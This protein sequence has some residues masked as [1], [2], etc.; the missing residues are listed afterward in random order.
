MPTTVVT[1][2]AGFIGSHVCDALLADGHRVIVVDNFCTGRP[3]NLAHLGHEPRLEL[4]ERDACD[5]LELP[6]RVDYVLHLASPASPSPVSPV[7]Y[8]QLPIETLRAGSVATLAT[9]ELARQHGA[10]Y[11]LASTSE[12]YGDPQVNPQPEDYPG[13]VSPVAL[14]SCYDEAKRFA[15]AA[16]M[17]YHRKYGLRTRIARIFNTYGPRMRV[18]DGRV[19]PN[20]ICQALTEQPLT[21]YG[22][23][24]QTRSFC[25][26]EDLVRGLIR[27]LFSDVIQP[28]NLG[29]PEAIT[30][31]QLAR[32]VL[33]VTGST[34]GILYQPAPE[35]D[36]QLRQP[37]IRRA[38]TLLGW[39][40]RV[41]RR[42]GLQATIDYFR[43]ELKRLGKLPSSA[44]R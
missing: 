30:I 18:D 6:G 25:Y 40:P 15:E 34:V 43:H 27:L 16:T 44:A 31:E 5:P 13:N 26:I 42:F 23:G 32:E 37:D 17:A 12:V 41:P 1:G 7:S 4:L 36:P 28:V 8:F 14:R 3:E 33:E 39:E 2:G 21:I 9:L 38:R 20:F 35:G 11:L 29:D 19:L 10:V 24:Q 22:S